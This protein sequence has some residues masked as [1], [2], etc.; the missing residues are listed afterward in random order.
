MPEGDNIDY[1]RE[2]LIIVLRY[3]NQIVVSLDRIGSTYVTVGERAGDELL[4][5]FV[6]NWRVTE[7]LLHVRHILCQPFSEELGPDQMGELEREM[8]GIIYWSAERR[9]PPDDLPRAEEGEPQ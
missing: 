9:E 4:A 6:T 5:E 2:D 3:L 8:E 1:R 7:K